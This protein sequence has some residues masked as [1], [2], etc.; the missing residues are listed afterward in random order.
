[1]SSYR[2]FIDP[3]GGGGLPTTIKAE[4]YDAKAETWVS[5]LPT[6]EI[7]MDSPTDDDIPP[8]LK[9]CNEL[10]KISVPWHVSCIVHDSHSKSRSDVFKAKLAAWAKDNNIALEVHFMSDLVKAFK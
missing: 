9:L 2:I 5:V 8:T 1:M 3:T 4:R 7:Y 10:F 6:K